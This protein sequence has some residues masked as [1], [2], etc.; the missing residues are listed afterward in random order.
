[1]LVVV[2]A[3]HR[4]EGEEEGRCGLPERKQSL[5]ISNRRTIRTGGGRTKTKET[6][7]GRKSGSA[8]HVHVSREINS[9]GTRP[10]KEESS[11]EDLLVRAEEGVR[12]F[13]VCL[14]WLDDG[15]RAVCDEQGS[16]LPLACVA[17]L[18]EAK[19]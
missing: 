7:V 11:A 3:L 12:P 6:A 18:E 19:E 2:L 14:S 9:R 4:T 10:T 15:I 13:D 8:N 16:R 1:M 17:C 5:S